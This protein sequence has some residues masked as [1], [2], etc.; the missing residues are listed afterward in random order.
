MSIS[1]AAGIILVH[2]SGEYPDVV[3]AGSGAPGRPCLVTFSVGLERKKTIIGKK[4]LSFH[5]L[6]LRSAGIWLEQMKY[7]ISLH[8][9]GVPK[10]VS[11]HYLHFIKA[12]QTMSACSPYSHCG[13]K[14]A[15]FTAPTHAKDEEGQT[16]TLEGD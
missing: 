14:R 3:E 10:C 15:G 8:E 5:M 9:Q 7:H 13:L 1:R 6:V 11:C 2:I 16:C 4:L 12:V